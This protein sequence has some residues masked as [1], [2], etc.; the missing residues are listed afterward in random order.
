[1]GQRILLRAMR[2]AAGSETLTLNLP[3]GTVR[4]GRAWQALIGCPTP[5]GPVASW[6]QGR[7]TDTAGVFPARAPGPP[8]DQL[9]RSAAGPWG[10]GRGLPEVVS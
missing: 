4:S 1:M 6:A 3:V 7:P 10:K 9:A 5:G 8:E 2:H